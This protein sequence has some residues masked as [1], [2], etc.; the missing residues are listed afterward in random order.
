MPT[1]VTKEQIQAARKADLYKFLLRFHL[2]DVIQEGDSIRLCDNHSVSIKEGYCGYTDF[3]TDETGNSIECLVNYFDYDFVKA[4]KALCASSHRTNPEIHAAA[5]HT[6]TAADPAASGKNQKKPFVLPEPVTGPCMDLSSYLSNIRG[7]SVY[8]LGDLAGDG[9]LYMERSH[10]NIVFVNPERN[11]AEIRGSDPDHPFHQVMYDDD[12]AAFW[13]FKQNGPYSEPTIAYICESAIDAISLYCIHRTYSH[14]EPN[15]LYCSIAGVSNQ[16]RI[17][18]IKAGMDAAGL[19]TILAVD[20]D[21]AGEQ[22]RR[23]NPD[24]LFAVPYLKDW[25]E[26]LVDMIKKDGGQNENL[27]RLLY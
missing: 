24:C 2:N 18:R 15:G 20:N 25:N 19:K 13:W 5:Q 11:F 6:G 12:P 17:D 7:I 9:I 22:C 14:W 21:D 26:D 8:V 27:A 16:Q 23:R 3:A 10:K 4:V 1:S